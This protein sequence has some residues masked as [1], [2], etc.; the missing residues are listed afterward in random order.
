MSS[1]D[2]AQLRD[3]IMSLVTRYYE[4]AHA[5]KP[6]VPGESKIPY[7]GRVYDDEE[8]R[9]GVESMLTCSKFTK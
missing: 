2:A 8:M 9:L 6:F 7:A 5:K 3:E 4:V 1:P